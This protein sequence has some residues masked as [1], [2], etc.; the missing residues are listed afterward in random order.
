MKLKTLVYT[1]S[2]LLL[3]GNVACSDFLETNPTDQVTE[4]VAVKNVGNLGGI[5]QEAYKTLYDDNGG[6]AYRGL[7]GF[8]SYIDLRGQ[9]LISVQSGGWNPYSIYQ[10]QPFVTEGSGD[11]RFLWNFFYKVIRQTNVILAHIDNVPGDNELRNSVKGQA[12]AL[13]AYSYFYL[14]QFF[15]QTYKGNENLKNVILRTEPVD[16]ANSGASRASTQEVYD[17]IRQDL[18][19]A[20]GLLSPADGT[21]SYEIN[22][23]IAQAMLSKVSLV[24]NEWS[25]A[26]S[27]ANAA[28]QGFALMEPIDYLKGFM[29]NPEVNDANN[30]EWIWYLPQTQRTSI[31]DATPSASWTNYN[32]STIKWITD[33]ICAS[34]DLISLYETTDVRFS[35]FWP[36]NDLNNPQTGGKIWT[37]NKF[38]EFY[39]GAFEFTDGTPKV[40]PNYTGTNPSTSTILSTF[41]NKNVD[42]TYIGQLNLLRAADL[43]LVEAEAMVRQGGAKE[44]TGRALLNEL[45]A[46]RNAS[47]ISASVAGNDL[48]EEILKE[49]RRELYGEGTYL[50]DM[51]RTKKGL[52][53]GPDHP[54]QLDI[55][56]G[57]YR[58]ILQIPADEFTY[59]KML[60]PTNDQNPFQGTAIPSNMTKK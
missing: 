41:S 13:R 51:L 56:A 45:R 26:E 57:D 42:N 48:L 47:A 23:N 53:R 9:D 2:A 54:T 32:R 25:V 40:N 28:R 17:L 38:S 11:V 22:K 15:Q 37:S 36:R 5:L 16:P 30:P 55:P 46:K 27:M 10:Y 8:Q 21:V 39:K 43:W 34:N 12:L 58:F 49:R 3:L 35:Q 19:T 18:N 14:A 33:M 1:I 20:I 4:D 60:S 59:N 24:T 29:L 44:A 6:F 50:F 52:K 7:I 31:G